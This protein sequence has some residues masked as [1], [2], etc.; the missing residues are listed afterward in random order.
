MRVSLV[1]CLMLFACSTPYQQSGVRG[2]YRDR[3]MGQ[4]RF[5][6]E[7]KVNGYTSSGTALEYLHRRSAEVCMAAGYAEYVFED[8]AADATYGAFRVGNTVQMY[9]KPELS[10][11]VRCTRLT[12]LNSASQP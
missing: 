2:G 7:V 8:S 11:I 9:S 5:F 12:R 1:A 10:A 6:V 3:P 4:G